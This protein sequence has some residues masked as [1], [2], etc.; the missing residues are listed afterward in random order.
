MRAQVTAQD[1]VREQA[2]AAYR[3]AVL[4]A[5]EEIENALVALTKN[6]E[7]EAALATAVESARLA[8][9]LARERYTAGLV[10]FQSVLDTDRTV[11]AVE[12]SLAQ[13]RADGVQALVRLYRSLGGGWSPGPDTGTG[14]EP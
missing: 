5:L 9:A 12:E 11:L 1:A 8:D 13:S 4:T 2:L 7:R 6:A 14:A 3:Q 10:D